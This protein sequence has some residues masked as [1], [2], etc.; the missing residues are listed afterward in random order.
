MPTPTRLAQSPCRESG[1]ERG[2]SVSVVPAPSVD[3]ELGIDALYRTHGTEV[4]RFLLRELGNRQDAEDATQTVFVSA[5][6]SITRGCV[7][8]APRAWLFAIARNAARRAWRERSRG[9]A[10]DVDVDTLAGPSGADAARRDLVDALAA[11]PAG[12]RQ[13]LV[14]HELGGLE[15]A[16]IAAATK[17][18]VAGVETAIFRARRTCRAELRTDGALDHAAAEKLLARLVAG[19]LTRSERESVEGHL[20]SCGACTEAERALRAA[21]PRRARRLLAWLFSF[22]DGLQRLAGLLQA[23]TPR[24][25]AALAVAGVAVAGGGGGPAPDAHAGAATTRPQATRIAVAVAPVVRH[26]G[27]AR[28]ASHAEPR[29]AASARVGAHPRVRAQHPERTRPVTRRAAPPRKAAAPPRAPVA[30]P[31]HV[32]APASAP[33]GVATQ[34]AHAAAS[35]LPIGPLVGTLQG[36]VG[37]VTSGLP[38]TTSTVVETVDGVE[39][40]VEQVADDLA[41]AR[42]PLTATPGT[43]SALPVPPP[44]EPPVA[45]VGEGAA[46]TVS[47]ITPPRLGTGAA[48]P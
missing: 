39:T 22:P 3:P 37:A 7:P 19:K 5:F 36:T 14:L 46:A 4:Y 6:R 34:P 38:E 33:T 26:S 31:R 40:A 21:R 42:D 18:T 15:Y 47:G 48:Q 16:E 8:R 43:S 11:V 28:P 32:P 25:L 10:T 27:P 12:Q 45:Q 9:V 24:A 20:R 44:L 1:D 2:W 30:T 17:Q 29:P 13:A 23:P 35:P 41:G